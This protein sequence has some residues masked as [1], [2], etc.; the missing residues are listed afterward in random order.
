[1][2]EGLSHWQILINHGAVVY[3]TSET[4][5]AD[6][7]SVF[8]KLGF[9][10]QRVGQYDQYGGSVCVSGAF[11]G[12]RMLPYDIKDYAKYSTAR[13][14]WALFPAF[15]RCISMSDY[16]CPFVT[17]EEL[18]GWAGTLIGETTGARAVHGVLQPRG[19]PRELVNLAL[20]F[21]GKTQQFSV[22]RGPTQ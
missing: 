5:R 14:H 21:R 17:N 12:D 6:S 3:V 22:K 18:A 19:V 1:M 9:H 10:P 11:V 2:E 7:L 15:T 8:V 16:G 20:E 4:R 13:S